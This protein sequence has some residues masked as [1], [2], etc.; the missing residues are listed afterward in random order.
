MSRRN[1][2]YPRTGFFVTIINL[3]MV[4]GLLTGCAVKIQPVESPLQPPALTPP[5]NPELMTF[6]PVKFNAQLSHFQGAN[7]ALSVD[8]LD[9]VT[10]LD[11]IA[12]R[13][14]MQAVDEFNFTTTIDLPTYGETKYRYVL[15]SSGNEPETDGT[16]Q[17]ISFRNVYITPDTSVNDLILGWKSS[18]YNGEFGRVEGS[19]TDQVSGSTVS[20][21]MIAIAGKIA[22]S[23]KT[24]RFHLANVPV[25]VH[26]LTVTSIDGTYQVFQ[27]EVNVVGGLST[28]AIVKLTALPEVKITFVVSPPDDAVG[29]PIRMAGNFY[30]FGHIYPY[31]SEGNSTTAIRMPV[32]DKMPDGRY[33]LQVKLHA[34]SELRYKYTMGDGYINAERDAE[35][36]RLTRRLIVP[37]RDIEIEDQILSWRKDNLEPASITIRVNDAIAL[38]D[39]ISLQLKGDNWLAPIPMWPIGDN[40]WMY[41][42][43]EDPASSYSYQ[44]CRNDL[45]NVAFDVQSHN[46]PV[47]VDFSVP[48][49]NFLEVNQWN[50]W[51]TAQAST[52]PATGAVAPD[53]K[54]LR[55]VEFAPDYQAGHLKRQIDVLP[56][57]VNLGINWLVLTP[58]WEVQLVNGLP[59]F[60]INAQS[61]VSLADLSSVIA[62][63]QAQGMQVG[64][65]PQLIFE[66]N[67]SD[68]WQS[69]IR[70]QLWWQQWYYEYDRFAMNFAIF[71]QETGIDQLILGGAG[72]SPSFPDELITNERSMGTPK[73][74][75]EVWSEL[76]KKLKSSYKGSLLWTIPVRG[77]NLPTYPFLDQM[78]GFYLE[79]DSNSEENATYSMETISKYMDSVIVSFQVKYSKPFYLGLNSPS[80]LSFRSDQDL[81]DRVVSPFSPEYGP[82]NVTMESQAYFYDTYVTVWKE[83]P[84]IFGISSRGFF[85]V[86]ELTDFSSSI[87]GK[88]AFQSFLN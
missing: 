1:F 47:Q 51:D 20:D 4:F 45:C 88:P 81:Y 8:I 13:Y 84:W 17:I 56:D 75:E 61:S 63:A 12:L 25:G 35:G 6:V 29:A 49:N 24:G 55:G 34:G 58:T 50:L 83:R 41:L 7:L 19:V 43:Y 71:A 80:M 42:L 2:K 82:D 72:V 26:R 39:W 10:G 18:S 73:S 33:T 3:S 21:V 70:D 31:S 46:S 40:Q 22:Y 60:S 11:S 74:S 14:P 54:N 79:V 68:W 38:H 77:G 53:G 9:D 67:I 15:T 69:T 37:S 23:D 48:E 27:Q 76:V 32:M 66:P 62:A 28:P 64:L 30:Q 57:L 87:Y 86:V 85:P 65:Y 52:L 36:N 16:N 5:A 78:D 44:V 59:Y